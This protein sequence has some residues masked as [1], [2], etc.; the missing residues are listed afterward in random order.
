MEGFRFGPGREVG[1]EI[2]LAQQLADDLAG[3]IALTELFDLSEDSGE[4]L[5]GLRD[6]VVR[7]ELT[8]PFEAAVVLDELFPEEVG[9]ALAGWTTEGAAGR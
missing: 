3:I 1:Y 6:R 7:V 9:E 5:F 4:R 2:E 8:L